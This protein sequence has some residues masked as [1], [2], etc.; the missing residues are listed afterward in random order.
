MALRQLFVICA[1]CRCALKSRNLWSSGS[2]D[3]VWYGLW[4]W[5][6]F[7]RR[8][9]TR[10][11]LGRS[12]EEQRGKGGRGGYGAFRRQLQMVCRHGRG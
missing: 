3:V 10:R 1:L 2:G 11:A 12:M 8:E 4:P 9:G 5:C 7:A 6:K